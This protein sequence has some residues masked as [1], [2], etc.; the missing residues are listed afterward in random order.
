MN[1]LEGQANTLSYGRSVQWYEEVALNLVGSD[2]NLSHLF[3]F[4]HI[5]INPLLPTPR[6]Y[7]RGA[8]YNGQLFCQP[9][10]LSGTRAP[11]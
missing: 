9:V 5:L 11:R 3:Y 6:F 10:H 1:R 4:P 2:Q 8:I 7:T